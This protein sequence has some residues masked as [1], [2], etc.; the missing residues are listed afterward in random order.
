MITITSITPDAMING[1]PVPRVQEIKGRPNFFT[2]K[3]LKTDIKDNAGSINTTRGGG[4]NGHLGA[5]MTAAAYNRIAPG[6]P[7]I[8]PVNPGITPALAQGATAA[9]IA[10]AVRQHEEALREWYEFDAMQKA[11]KKQIMGAIEKKFIN[12]LRGTA[13]FN[14]ITVAQM[15]E[16]LF[17][18][19]GKLTNT[20]LNKNEEEMKKEWDPA[21]SFETII[22]QIDE[23]IEFAEGA[24]RPYSDEQIL[25]IAYTIVQNTGLYAQDLREWDRKE[26]WQ[27]DWSPEFK[28]FMLKREDEVLKQQISAKQAGYKQANALY[29]ENRIETHEML[30][31]L[32]TATAHDRAALAGLATTNQQ[33]MQSMKEAQDLIKSLKGQLAATTAGMATTSAA[34]GTG[35]GGKQRRPKRIPKDEGSYCW[36]HGFLVIKNHNSGNCKWPKLPG[37]QTEATRENPMGGNMDGDPSKK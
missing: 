14:R 21:D 7:Y 13:G 25:D 5:T 6:T 17:D 20:E 29:Q 2:L 3:T 24:G 10:E 36:T 4:D 16:Y 11:L 8:A 22:M 30:A 33:L 15:F 18:K 23:C 31:N 9:Q 26:R 34:T 19:Y 27:K 12:P 35:G 32:V 1:F 28:D 37:H